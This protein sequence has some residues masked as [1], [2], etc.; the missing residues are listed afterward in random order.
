MV[1]PTD[2][3]SRSSHM[4]NLWSSFKLGREKE[5]KAA[6]YSPEGT[7]HLPI[8]YQFQRESLSKIKEYAK[9]NISGH[10]ILENS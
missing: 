4:L 3:D 6:T 10:E 8:Y 5:P 2:E 1:A 9:P 7:P